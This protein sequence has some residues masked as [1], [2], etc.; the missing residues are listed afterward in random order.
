MKRNLNDK[1]WFRVDKRQSQVDFQPIVK[2]RTSVY[3]ETDENS[4]V[5]KLLTTRILLLTNVSR[6]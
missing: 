5:V 6:D 4:F 1:F 3:V 2:R